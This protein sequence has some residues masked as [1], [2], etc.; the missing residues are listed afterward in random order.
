MVELLDDDL[1]MNPML[2]F[3]IF[4]LKKEI[5]PEQEKKLNG[6]FLFHMFHFVN[7]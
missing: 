3:N 5:T 7:K 1:V 6:K 2:I 4:I